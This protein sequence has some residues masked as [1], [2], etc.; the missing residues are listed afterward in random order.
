MIKKNQQ[1]TGKLAMDIE[2]KILSRNGFHGVTESQSTL[3]MLVNLHCRGLSHFY[4][5]NFEEVEGAY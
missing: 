4:A 3:T 5:P 1:K 2:V